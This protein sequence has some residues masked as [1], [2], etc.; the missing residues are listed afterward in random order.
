MDRRP[1]LVVEESAAIPALNT[2]ADVMRRPNRL[3]ADIVAKMETFGRFEFD[4]VGSGFDAGY[5]WTQLVAPL[6]P[7]AQAD[8]AGFLRELAGAVLPVGGWA[9]YGGS[10]LV[11]EL[12]SGDLDDPSYHAMMAASLDFLRELGV[13]NLRL[14]GYES[15]FWSQH[16]GRT[17]P[18]LAARPRPNN[19]VLTELGEREE[20]RI[21]QLES[22][23]S[24][25][26]YVRRTPGGGFEAIIEGRRSDEDPTR[27]RWDW[28]KAPSLY[29][30]YRDVA[31]A[32]QVP[33][34]WCHPELEPFFPY[35]RPKISWLP[36]QHV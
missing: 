12:L 2:N 11:K 3:P 15:L 9:V 6:L 13:P 23:E 24:N 22:G 8:S 29:E 19:P 10:H 34:F 21:A 33:S 16:K 25:D 31:E 5:I 36:A 27:V 17:E 4:P 20:R 30:L 35:P 18:W 28:K 32:L 1:A 14:N 26:I 7:A